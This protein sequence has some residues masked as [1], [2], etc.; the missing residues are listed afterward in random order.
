LNKGDKETE[1]A[2]AALATARNKTAIAQREACVLLMIIL[3]STRTER[4]NG[5]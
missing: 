5:R 1:A 4:E 3:H 2:E